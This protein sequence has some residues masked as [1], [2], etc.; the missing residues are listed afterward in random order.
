MDCRGATRLR[1][2]DC[3]ECDAGTGKS[4][5]GAKR[6]TY[7]SQDSGRYHADVTDPLLA[8]SVAALL[9]LVHFQQVD[10]LS[11]SVGEYWKRKD[12]LA[13]TSKL[14]FGLSLCSCT[15]ILAWPIFGIFCA[16]TLWAASLG[17]SMSEWRR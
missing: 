3:F 12:T 4:L 15:V 11:G 17:L 10:I 2:T 7:C 5:R 13:R 1:V 6:P 14:L 9:T 16:G 8:I